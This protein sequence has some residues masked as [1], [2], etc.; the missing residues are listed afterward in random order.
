M[1]Q[2]IQNTGKLIAPEGKKIGL[3]LTFDF[4][5]ASVWMESFGKK[6]T[7]VCIKR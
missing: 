7:C 2:N 4:D 3:S 5:A 6:I 1:I